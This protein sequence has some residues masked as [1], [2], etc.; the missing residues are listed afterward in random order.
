MKI[1]LITHIPM[2]DQFNMG[3]TFLSLFS[4]FDKADLCQLYIYPTTPNVDLCTS[5]YRITDKEVVKSYYRFGSI[6]NEI[7]VDESFGTMFEQADDEKLYRNPKNKNDARMLARDLIW[8]FAHWYNKKLKA[9]LDRENPTCIFVAPGSAKFLYDI[10][11]KI[12]NKRNIP[13]VTYVCD[14]FYFVKSPKNFLGKLRTH[15]L[16]KKIQKLVNSSKNLIVICD[17]LAKTYSNEFSVSATKIMTGS[18]YL[19]EPKPG[20]TENPTEI[21]YFGNIRCNRFTSLSDI[22]RA[23]DRINAEKGLEFKLNIYTAEKDANILSS[24][25]DIKSIKLCPF[26]SG[27]ELKRAFLASQLLLH[28]EAF[29]DRSIDLVKHSVS[30]KIADALASGV[31]L[32]A[33]APASISSMEHLLSNKCAITATS[34]D[35]LEDTLDKAFFDKTLRKTVVSHAIEAAKE[36]HDHYRNSERLKQIFYDIHG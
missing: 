19:A 33:Y 14:D 5:F 10:A 1:L 16:Q 3:K 25:S 36:H 21:T 32:L 15:A 31:P 6:G 11:L 28:V 24:F 23:L 26:I 34:A 27:D 7:A 9:W 35:E 29:D 30:T 8:K 20:I 22:G 18:S 13:I 12:S 4:S 2:N 17:A